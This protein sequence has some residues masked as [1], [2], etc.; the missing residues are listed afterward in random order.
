M[1]QELLGLPQALNYIPGAL[2][3]IPWRIIIAAASIRSIY[4]QPVIK[5]IENTFFP[6]VNIDLQYI[7]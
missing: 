4:I 1:T 6:R 2:Y 5:P 3:A 7:M